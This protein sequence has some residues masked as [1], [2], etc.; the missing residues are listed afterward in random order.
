MGIEKASD[1]MEGFFERL[2]RLGQSRQEY[3]NHPS[4]EILRAYLS[5]G[6]PRGIRRSQEVMAGLAR[7][8]LEDWHQAEVGLH[9]KT[10]PRCAQ[11]VAQW[12]MEAAEEKPSLLKRLLLLFSS[13]REPVLRPAG[14][15]RTRGASLE[16]PKERPWGRRLAWAASLA[17]TFAIGLGVGSLWLTGPQLELRPS[18]ITKAQIDE[19][20]GRVRSE[21]VLFHPIALLKMSQLLQQAGIDLSRLDLEKPPFE[22]KTQAGETLREIALKYYGEERY[23]VLI[24]L[25]NYNYSMLQEVLKEV[26]DPSKVKLPEG[27]ILVLVAKTPKE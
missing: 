24:Y 6:L 4:E 20:I 8:Q 17:A 21:T 25:L 13:A 3:P 22:Y 26:D 23:W 5:K 19:T 18:E 15:L 16:S 2:G 1:A 12:R 11:L 10:C 27:L 7:G 14:A 9:V